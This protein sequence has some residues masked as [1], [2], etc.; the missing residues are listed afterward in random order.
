M[1]HLPDRIYKELCKQA[2]CNF[3][4]VLTEEAISKTLIYSGKGIEVA[5][6]GPSDSICRFIY[7]LLGK[8]AVTADWMTLRNIKA[9]FVRKDFEMLKEV[10]AELQQVLQACN[11]RL[12]LAGSAEEAVFESFVGNVIALLPFCYPEI[13][14][15]FCIPQKVEG[16]W[17]PVQYTVEE[18]IELSPKTVASPICA[19]GLV[20]K[21]GPPLLTFIGTTYPAGDGFLATLL[22]DIT[23]GF[24]V[25]HAPYLFGKRKIT[26][27]L[28]TK[29]GTQLYGIS[30]GGALIFH[31]V[32]HHHELIGKVYA[33]NPPGLYPWNWKGSFRGAGPQI[34]I[35]YQENDPIP[36][37]GTFPE[38]EQVRVYRI[39]SKKKENF[40][41]AHSIVFTGGKEV[42]LLMSCP[43]Y[44]NRRVV[45]KLFT[46]FHILL[47]ILFSLLPALFA[48]LLYLSIKSLLSNMN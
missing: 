8:E 45:R 16:I 33:Y 26:K 20:S 1:N 48:Y 34:F 39:L 6:E 9:I 7:Y 37:I 11:E 19:Y 24:S 13:G 2:K 4:G 15:P 30:L 21:S 27:W 32:R 29:K 38:G 40:L 22:S 36:M 10:C 17:Q 44:E 18:K 42:T 28:K 43:Y 35:Y 41:K 47:S 3:Q 5:K 31:V 25:G 23:P 46:A 14:T 12:P